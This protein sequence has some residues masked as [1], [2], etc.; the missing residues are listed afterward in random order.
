MYRP[1]RWLRG[2][3]EEDDLSTKSFTNL[4]WGHGARMCIGKYRNTRIASPVELT[5]FTSFVTSF[6][7]S[8]HL[9][10]FIS[11]GFVQGQM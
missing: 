7:L 2:D 3:G 6:V 1:E 4:P 9:T 5:L 11:T 8:F 10:H